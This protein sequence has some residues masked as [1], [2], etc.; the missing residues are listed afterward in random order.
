M[1]VNN[2]IG[3][4]Q[5]IEEIGTIC[6]DAN[7]LFHTDAA[8]AIGKIPIDVEKMGI[9]LMSVSG[10]K[11]YGPKGI[12]ALYVRKKAPRVRIRP[13]IDGGGQ[14]FGVRSG[15]LPPHLCVGLGAAVDLCKTEM[16]R[17][18]KHIRHLSLY[19]EKELRSKL[20]A[21]YF[22]LLLLNNF[23]FVHIYMCH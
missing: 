3:T 9:H 10:H 21:V 1:Y 8:Q 20:D 6:K 14:E 23:F 13:Q 5:K 19:L 2:E 7:I 4:M 11:V 18:H 17:D 12:G 22:H 15:T 16:D